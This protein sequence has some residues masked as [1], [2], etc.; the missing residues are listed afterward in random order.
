MSETCR[1]V[2]QFHVDE[3]DRSILEAIRQTPG[4][5]TREIA[6]ATK[7][8]EYVTRY[9]LWTLE[10]IGAVQSTKERNRVR[11]YINDEASD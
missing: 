1:H 6:E 10:M 11:Y 5:I 3:K 7:I 4:A 2:Q 9:R 8:S